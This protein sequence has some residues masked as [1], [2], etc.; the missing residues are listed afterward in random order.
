MRWFRMY[1]DVL[2]DPKVQRLTPSLFKSWVN[3]LCLASKSEVNGSLPGVAEIAFR[4]RL[5]EAQAR[6]TLA[7]LRAAGLLDETETGVTPH[8]WGIRQ[9]QSDD[10]AKRVA[11]HRA[12]VTRNVTDP[13]PVTPPDTDTDIDT[14]VT[15]DAVTERARTRAPQAPTTPPKPATKA[16]AQRLPDGW[17]PSGD[18]RSWAAG[19]G[20]GATVIDTETAKF[21]DHFQATG[22]PMLDWSAAWRN[23]LRRSSEF[24]PRPVPLRPTNGRRDLGLSDEQLEAIARGGN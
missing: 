8:N 16:R 3:L 1:D 19:E 12:A 15:A 10:V 18:D 6:K 23:W 21:A 24:S 13:L 2:D 5:T 4:L 17:A 7:E 14:D 20:F 22:K 9:R 11:K